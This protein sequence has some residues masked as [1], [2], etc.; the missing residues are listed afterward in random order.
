MTREIRQQRGAIGIG[1]R[2]S[3]KAARARERSANLVFLKETRQG[4]IGTPELAKRHALVDATTV[5]DGMQAPVKRVADQ[6]PLDRYRHRGQI[7]QVQWRAGDRIASLAFRAGLMPRVTARY[8]DMPRAPGPD[9]EATARDLARYDYRSAMTELGVVEWEE[10][11]TGQRAPIVRATPMA[12]VVVAVCVVEQDAGEW[13]AAK[14]TYR[15]T[16]ARVEGLVTLR[17]ALDRLAR[18]WRL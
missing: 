4:D 10:L 13:A 5:V 7:T 6:R 9:D 18:H 15:G 11:P 2:G 8:S 3:P 12:S 17:L 14:G 16:Q 1:A